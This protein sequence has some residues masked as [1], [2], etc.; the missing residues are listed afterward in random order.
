MIDRYQLEMDFQ[1][2]TA[3]RPAVRRGRRLTRARW[4]FSQM[5]QVVEQSLDWKTG[6]AGRRDQTNLTLVHSRS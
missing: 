1:S 4:W 5:H 2:T 6:P 3:N